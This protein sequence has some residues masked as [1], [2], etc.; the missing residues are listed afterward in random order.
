M[1]SQ[2]PEGYMRVEDFFR[3]PKD[4]SIAADVR[5]QTRDER[6]KTVLDTTLVRQQEDWS[7]LADKNVGGEGT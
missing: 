7:F 4:T 2:A 6:S 5:A 1:P 3:S